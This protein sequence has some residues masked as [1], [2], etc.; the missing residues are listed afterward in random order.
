[1]LKFE[2]LFTNDSVIHFSD[3]TIV[4]GSEEVAGLI[5]DCCVNAVKGYEK[6]LMKSLGYGFII[7]VVGAGSVMGYNYYKKSRKLKTQGEA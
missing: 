6:G 4:K 3:G 2:S 1:M 7:G 5:M